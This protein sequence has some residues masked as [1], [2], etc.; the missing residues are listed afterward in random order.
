MPKEIEKAIDDCKIKIEKIAEDI[1]AEEIISY[2]HFPLEECAALSMGTEPTELSTI[3][4]IKEWLY[5]KYGDLHKYDFK[6]NKK[7]KMQLLEVYS[8]FVSLMLFESLVEPIK[9]DDLVLLL[10]KETEKQMEMLSED[11]CFIH[12]QM[13]FGIN[14]VLHKEL[15]DEDIP[16]NSGFLPLWTYQMKNVYEWCLIN[17]ITLVPG[18]RSFKQQFKNIKEHMIDVGEHGEI[19]YSDC[20]ELG[21]PIYSTLVDNLTYL[22]FKYPWFEDVVSH[23]KQ[24]RLEDN[25]PIKASFKP[26]MWDNFVFNIPFPENDLLKRDLEL[27]TPLKAKKIEQ[28][29]RWPLYVDNYYLKWS[30]LLI[31][32]SIFNYEEIFT[33]PKIKGR[34]FEEILVEDLNLYRIPIL[35]ENLELPNDLGDVDIITFDEVCHYIIEAKSW[36]PRSKYGYFSST[37]YE[38]RLKELDREVNKL[39]KRLNFLDENR[40]QNNIPKYS[41]LVGLFATGYEEPHL[42]LPEEIHNLTHSKICSIFGGAPINP[43]LALKNYEMKLSK[44]NLPSKKRL[45][46]YQPQNKRKR[47]SLVERKIAKFVSS[48][49]IEIFGSISA[50]HLF[51]A[52]CETYYAIKKDEIG[53]KELSSHPKVKPNVLTKQYLSY[54]AYRTDEISLNEIEQDLELLMKLGFIKNNNGIISVMKI[55]SIE[56]WRLI[57]GKIVKTN[58]KRS[59]NIIINDFKIRRM[60][61]NRKVFMFPPAFI[62][63][64]KKSYFLNIRI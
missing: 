32:F 62:R 24:H 52:A 29:P 50:S 55:P 1:P 23:Y 43:H 41:A 63:Y 40:Y 2:L 11:P 5:N 21:F 22:S 28:H 12:K 31:G 15:N 51:R 46:R 30:S 27:F 44:K 61:E 14:A 64:R 33:N 4:I 56:Y 47:T 26:H 10:N 48:R 49:L 19:S 38:Q 35:N 3:L 7:N 25:L 9:A 18:G 6:I 20:F 42:E 16:R 53:V 37:D 60:T 8:T 17:D 39:Y 34:W 54:I 45:R 57:K 58:N 36:G 59:A 13:A